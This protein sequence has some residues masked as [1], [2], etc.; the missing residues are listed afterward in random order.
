MLNS[1]VS[2]QSKVSRI[3]KLIEQ[4]AIEAAYA[5]KG[6]SS[7]AGSSNAGSLY[8]RVQAGELKAPSRFQVEHNKFL[9][10]RPNFK[11][12]PMSG[13][14]RPRRLD[15]IVQGMSSMYT[16]MLVYR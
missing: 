4:E 16:S 3:Q 11:G 1:S 15:L 10:L 13:E 2:A 14:A 8:D 12:Y 5:A 7:N 6:S 9:V